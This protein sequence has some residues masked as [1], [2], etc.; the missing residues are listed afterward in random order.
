MEAGR[1]CLAR[2]LT[3]DGAGVD[4]SNCRDPEAIGARNNLEEGIMVLYDTPGWIIE[5]KSTIN[6]S[7]RDFV[8]L[9]SAGKSFT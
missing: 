8:H 5:I 2:A 9:D 3:A 1:H 6:R 7:L 4:E